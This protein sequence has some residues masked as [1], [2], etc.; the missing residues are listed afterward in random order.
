VKAQRDVDRL[1]PLVKE[2]AAAQQDLDNALAALD[3]NQA[4]VRARQAGVEQ[5]RLST[6]AQ[7]DTT[8]G[9]VQSQQ[10]A[11]KAAELNLEYAT[12]RA[13][14]SGRVGDSLVQVGGLVT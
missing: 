6:K 10:A 12:I 7:I 4:S 5:A 11:L 9:Q 8:V 1:R 2:E 13:P 3:A 14:I